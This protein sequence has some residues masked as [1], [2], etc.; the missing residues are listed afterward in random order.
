[1]EGHGADADADA[2]L[3]AMAMAM[4]MAGHY[5]CY[6]VRV[7][8]RRYLPSSIGFSRWCMLTLRI[9]LPENYS[10]LVLATYY[11]WQQLNGSMH[12]LKRPL[13]SRLC[14]N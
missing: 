9:R 3:M 8:A 6:S 10:E 7:W 1:M 13:P 5:K 2:Q 14:K 4:A 11:S 12:I